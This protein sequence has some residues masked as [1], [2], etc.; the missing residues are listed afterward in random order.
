[1]IDRTFPLSLAQQRLWF[2]DQLDSDTPSYNL[3]R[4]IRIEGSL[5]VS[6]LSRTL[7]IIADRHE[8]LR[9]A[10]VSNSGEPRQL[11]EPRIALEL[12]ETDLA[13]LPAANRM[14]EVERIAGE[15][16]NRPF[17]LSVPPLFQFRLIR[18][19]P[20]VHVLVFVMHHIITDGWS[21]SVFFR[22]IAHIYQRIVEDRPLELPEF[23]I[24]YSDFAQWQRDSVTGEHLDRQLAYWKDKLS[25]S[26]TYLEL[27]T[28]R[29]RPVVQS[30]RGASRSLSIDPEL[31]DVLKALSRR[32]GATLFMT[33]LAAFQVLLWRYTS[34]EDILIGTPIA[35]RNHLDL[36]NLIGLFVD[37]IILRGD[38]SGDPSFRAL[39]RRVRTTALEAYEHQDTPLERIVADLEPERSLSYTPLFQVMFVLQNAPK[40]IIELSGLKLEE[41]EF[42][43]GLAKFDLT[44]EIVELGGGLH[45]VFEFSTD[46]FDGS[47]IERFSRHFENLLRSI[48]RSPD[49]RIGDLQI[50]DSVEQNQ[51][52]AQLNETRRPLSGAATIHGLFEEQVTRTPEAIALI[53]GTDRITFGE[54]NRRANQIADY[55]LSR[56]LG[57]QLPVGVLVERSIDMVAAL[58]GVMKAGHP[59]LPLD[60]SY[61]RQRIASMMENS[62]T[63]LVLTHRG[64]KAL[65]LDSVDALRL[66]GDSEAIDRRSSSD[67]AILETP[68]QLAYVIY[69]S[70]STGRPKGVEGTHHGAI[71]RFE[72]M[73]RAWPFQPGEAT[74]LKTALGFVDSVWEIFGPL[75]KGVCAVIIPDEIVLQPERFVDLLHGHRVTRIVLVPSLLRVLLD[76]VP[77]L[78]NRLPD[79]RLC[80]T[81]GETLPLDLAKRC[82]AALP[83]TILLNLYGSSEVAAD[84]TCEEVKNLE[85]TS[86]VP[87]GRP[88]DNVQI[89]ILDSRMRPVPIGVRGEIYAGGDC[90]AR[91]YCGQPELTAERFVLDPF[92]NSQSKRLY[93]TGDLGRYLPDGRIEYLGRADNQVKLRGF[94]IEPGEIESILNEHPLL[95]ESVVT[96]AGQT[97]ESQ[98]LVAYVT[99]PENA[100]PGTAE[101]RQY[102]KARIPDYMIPSIFIALAGLPLLA[103]GKVNRNAL[104]PVQP[105]QIADGDACITPRNDTE[106]GLASIWQ[107]L[108]GIE[109][110]GINSNFFELGGHSLLGM[111]LLARIRKVFEVELPVRCLFEEP[112]ILG[113]GLE[114]EKARAAGVAVRAPIVSRRTRVGSVDAILAE[115]DKMPPDQVTALLERLLRE[116]QAAASDVS[117]N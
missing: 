90:L 37:T 49:T 110:I 96:V 107:Q 100:V 66:D 44:L 103:N 75:L 34:A 26:P 113:L 7:Q 24:Q 108:L 20:R 104:P 21:M 22:E 28:D 54:L 99:G 11:V 8:S 30:H 1:M 3:L 15:D 14:A 39:L 95:R 4:A 111:Q 61:P 117:L 78:Q 27:P 51:I 38:L 29:P 40:Q 59:Y 31:T 57:T 45:A 79:L 109:R 74:C 101:L 68:D 36:E 81:S 53:E 64:L 98:H 9:T 77:D 116:K 23:T 58:L 42:E 105:N 10:F 67:P 60:P 92:S 83:G 114:I 32:E 12:P 69:T 5:H 84:V 46:L 2:L 62:R 52:L 72:W 106:A 56:G 80:V 65:L 43:S 13:H 33:L 88:I 89:Y 6:A 70:G 93:K 86:S 25:G 87:I 16:A 91:G 82:R 50:L 35:G 71:N 115:L 17:D 63:P 18:L 47:T 73:W 76:Q 85:G 112:T 19:E 41:L 102:L 55:L 94:R 48:V 97:P